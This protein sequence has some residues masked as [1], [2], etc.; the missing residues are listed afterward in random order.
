MLRTTV[1]A[2]CVHQSKKL[3]NSVASGSIAATIYI[4]A[5]IIQTLR[6]IISIASLSCVLDR[7]LYMLFPLQIS[8]AC[9]E[10]MFWAW[11]VK[12][13]TRKKSQRIKFRPNKLAKFRENW[14]G[15]S[16]RRVCAGDDRAATEKTG[17]ANQ[18]G[19]GWVLVGGRETSLTQRL[20]HNC[21]V[22][23]IRV[24][25]IVSYLKQTCTVLNLMKFIKKKYINI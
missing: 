12:I 24:N 18:T 16:R 17:L 21:C 22:I 8:V 6:R 4:P 2:C 9:R 10:N 14:S 3:Q 13:Q 11:E 23:K 7:S 20:S 19:F 15:R 25:K 5:W 1:H